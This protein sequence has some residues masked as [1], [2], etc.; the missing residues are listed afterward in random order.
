MDREFTPEDI[1]RQQHLNLEDN[2][3]LSPLG[4]G[5]YKDV[6]YSFLGIFVL[7]VYIFAK[8]KGE[9]KKYSIWK[10]GTIVIPKQ[11]RAQRLYSRKHILGHFD[12]FSDLTNA[13]EIKEFARVYTLP[14]NVYP[15]WPGGNKLKG[16]KNYDIPDLFFSVPDYAKMEKIFLVHF[17]NLK[18]S[19]EAAM[20]RFLDSPR[21]IKSIREIFD[22][23]V[24]DYL[25]F[26]G[27]IIKEINDRTQEIEEIIKTN[28]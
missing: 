13:D 8:E 16:Q 1:I 23:S 5:K 21:R 6:L 3:K 10:D 22:F 25:E 14:G 28:R 11:P 15:I 19:E 9:E 7:G 27:E 12:S 20:T 26:V 24:K 4:W 18:S 17:L 2:E